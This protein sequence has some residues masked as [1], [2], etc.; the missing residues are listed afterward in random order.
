MPIYTTLKQIRQHKPCGIKRGS[1]IGYDKLRT[2]L[3]KGYGDNTPIAFSTIIESN[4]LDDALWCIRSVCPEHDKEARLFA[5][6]CAESVLHI[7]EKDYPNDN[8]PREAIKA[9]R[10]YANGLIGA[11]GAADREAAWAAAG[12]ATRAA[13]GEA[14]WEA[15][16]A[17]RA[18]AEEAWEAARLAARAAAWA[19]ARAAAAGEAVGEAAWAVAGEAARATARAAA[20]ETAGATAWEA[21]RATT[22]AVQ[23]NLLIHY[24]S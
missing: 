20:W 11:A 2:T 16:W 22:R 23:S 21:A 7:Y 12:E 3:G 13:A 19:A 18:A 1:N 5:S 8:R 9:A 10:G 14:A 24:F 17:A 6:D 15:S 4:G